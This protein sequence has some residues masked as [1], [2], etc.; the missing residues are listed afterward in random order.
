LARTLAFVF[1]LAILSPV[2]P[3]PIPRAD[4]HTPGRQAGF[5][6]VEVALAIAVI[7]FAFVALLSL[8]PAGLTTF[9]RALD[10]S[11]CTQIAQRIVADAHGADFDLVV[12][13]DNLPASDQESEFSFRAPTIA[14]PGV[15]FFDEQGNEIVPKAAEEGVAK[16]WSDLTPDEQLR[17]IYHVNVRVIPRVHLP[18][19]SGEGTKDGFGAQREAGEMGSLALLTVQIAHNPSGAQLKLNEADPEDEN[20]PDRNLWKPRDGVEMFTYT[21]Y[22]A[23]NQ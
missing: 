23:R 4:A 9:R 1:T 11:V 14:N 7:A 3:S 15:R 12:D 6:L 10:I 8:L 13:R 18:T 19:D 22:I 20:T 2:N 5:T 17:V 16:G 21:A